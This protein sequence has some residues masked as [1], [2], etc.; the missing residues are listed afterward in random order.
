MFVVDFVSTSNPSSIPII[1]VSK[2]LK[3]LMDKDIVN[4]KIGCS[5]GHNPQTNGKPCP[6][7]FVTPEVK[8]SHAH[9]SIKNKKSI[10]ALK[11]TV[12]IFVV[13]VFV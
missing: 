3:T 10:V 4:Y 12:V 13:M 5:I 8:T 1:G 6:E 11:P 7:P 2:H 9:Y